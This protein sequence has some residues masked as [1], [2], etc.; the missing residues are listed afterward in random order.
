M[1]GKT[2]FGVLLKQYRLA[3]GLSQEALAA[4]AGLSARG[5]SDLERGIKQKPRFD[6]LERLVGALS[7]STQQRALLQASARP[8][9]VPEQSASRSL[10]LSSVT[11][12]PHVPTSLIGANRNERLCRLSCARLLDAF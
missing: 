6:T 3:A 2:N 1:Q 5:I 12:L 11:G 7:L 4:R 10:L 8:E 9:R